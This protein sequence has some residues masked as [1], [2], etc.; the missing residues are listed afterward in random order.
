MSINEVNGESIFSDSSAATPPS[1]TLKKPPVKDPTNR[2]EGGLKIHKTVHVPASNKKNGVMRKCR[3]C[4]KHKI[5]KETSVIC[6]SCGVALCKLSC[7]SAYHMKKN[8]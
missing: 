6:A 4:A 1:A 5:R 7:F 8:Y 2:L 3:V